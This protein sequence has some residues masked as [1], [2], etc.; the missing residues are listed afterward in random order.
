[1]EKERP[2]PYWLFAANSAVLGFMVYLL[3]GEVG[4][5]ADGWGAITRATACVSFTF[6]MLAF[7][8]SSL[9][10]LQPTAFYRWLLQNRRYL[11]LNFAL[12][13][14][15][16]F[17]SVVV[18]FLIKGETPGAFIT[19]LGGAAY[20]FALAM[21]VTSTDRAVSRLGATRWK[22]LHTVGGYYIWT[23]FLYIYAGAA[24]AKE[25]GYWIPVGATVGVLCVRLLAAARKGNPL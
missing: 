3:M 25:W 7:S 9:A 16:H 14:G 20:A 11:G 10:R 5:G 19:I 21:A 23:V 4:A 6:F 8:A 24:Y 22:M 1:M 13:H 18:Y 12:A 15:V 2:I 17:I